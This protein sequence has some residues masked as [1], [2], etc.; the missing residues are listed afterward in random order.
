MI[1]DNRSYLVH[2]REQALRSV[3]I[4]AGNGLLALLGCGLLALLLLAHRMPPFDRLSISAMVLVGLAA[5]L[6][7]RFHLRHTPLKIEPAVA[8]RIIWCTTMLALVGVQVMTRSLEAKRLMGVGFLMTAPLVAQ[9][10]LVSALLG[11]AISLF[12]LTITALLLGVS[13]AMPVEMLT[14]SWLAGAVGAHA[15][16][17]LKQRG[18][19]LRAMSV[20][21]VALAAIALC[22]TAV[23]SN[24]AGLVFES[25]GWAALAAIGATSIFWLAVAVLERIF[26]ITSDWSLLELCSP[27]HPLLKEL[28]MRAPG[29]YAHSVMVGNLA[30]NAA[31]A[32]GANPVLC[33]AMAYFHDVGKVARPSLFIENQ[34]GGENPHDDLSPS[35]SAMIIRAHVDDGIELAKRHKLPNAIQAGIAEHHG[36]SLIGYFYAK[37]LEQHGFENHDSV[38]EQHYRYKGPKPQG[39]ETAILHLADSVEAAARTIGRNCSEELE[40][41]IGKIIEDRRADGQLD[42]CDITLRELRLIRESFLRSLCAIRHERV[43]YP[44]GDSHDAPAQEPHS[45]LERILPKTPH[46]AHTY[47]G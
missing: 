36:T 8:E 32:V 5:M 12:A 37:A 41:V 23:S 44:G 18:D 25:A 28:C 9:A 16:N 26:G 3:L 20:Q 11:P 39:R 43:V 13:G 40:T 21:V 1:D 38:L 46:D 35:I 10:M 15:V 29:T 6:L 34:I 19:L 17:P 47:G 42:E 31:R 30:E 14:A 33:R 4:Q 7:N 27:D 22:V 45:D 24:N 2:S